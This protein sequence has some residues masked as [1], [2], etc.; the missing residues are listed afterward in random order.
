MS[1]DRACMNCFI[2]HS[3]EKLTECRF[4]IKE[5]EDI[6]IC[7]DQ[8]IQWLEEE[9]RR[10]NDVDAS[11]DRRVDELERK[12]KDAVQLSKVRLLTSL[13]KGKRI[14][15]FQNTIGQKNHR[16]RELEI[17]LE[18]IESLEDRVADQAQTIDEKNRRIDALEG[19][20]ENQA[21]TISEKNR[22]IDGFQRAMFVSYIDELLEKL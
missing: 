18:Q 20:R 7:K 13:W 1:N 8:R 2:S 16:I 5:L 19:Y 15:Y 12:C 17:R 6:G 4:R 3:Q 9:H 10:R 11:K 21:R 14:E 22:T